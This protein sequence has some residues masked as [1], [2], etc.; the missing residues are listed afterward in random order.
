M[1]RIASLLLLML[2]GCRTG[3]RADPARWTVSRVVEVD[4]GSMVE[5]SDGRRF[6]T[7][8]REARY[9]DQIAAPGRAP[10]LVLAARGCSDCDQNLAVYLVFPTD[11][12]I[13]NQAGELSFPYPG[14]VAEWEPESAGD[15]IS[16]R[17]RFFLGD[18]LPSA[19]A[20]AIWF[21]DE[22]TGP[23]RLTPRVVFVQFVGGE[24][25]EAEL[26]LPVGDSGPRFPALDEVLANV[27]RGGCREIPGIEQPREP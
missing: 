25:V 1:R 16:S 9:L 15:T 7:G 4:D 11:T 26:A 12:P 10:Y 6:A 22:R 3:P 8:L 14:V 18:C 20:R 13:V 27:R 24:L 21:M 17:T 19:G 2:A 5:F 23:A